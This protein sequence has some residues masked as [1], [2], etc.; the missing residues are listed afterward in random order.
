M[1]R[2]IYAVAAIAIVAGIAVFLLNS[3]QPAQSLVDYD[4]VAVNSTTMS[5]LYAIANNQTLAATATAVVKVITPAA[6]STPLE[7]NGKPEVLYI[8]AEYC[9]YCASFRWGMALALMRFGNFST[10]RYMT[11]SATDYAPSTPTF[12]F[13]NAPYSSSYIYFRPVELT[14]N[15]L[16]ATTN[17]YPPLQNMTP[18]EQVIL[19][20]NDPHGSVPFADFGNASVAL[21][22]AFLP[23]LINGMTWGQIMSQ[24]EQQDSPI[25]QAIIGEANIYTAEI[26][27]EINNTAPVCSLPYVQIIQK[28]Q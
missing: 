9:P 25:S 13:Y 16:N 10:L 6:N 20:Q 28:T 15:K 22:S 4:N 24:I 23:T 19:Q 18:G 14:T 11:S 12:T 2:L 3:P 5:R 17:N 27:R 8:G 21:G 7:Y 26:C 1:N